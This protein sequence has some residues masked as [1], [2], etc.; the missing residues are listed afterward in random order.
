MSEV[1]MERAIEIV[2]SDFS[3]ITGEDDF[4]SS[5]GVAHINWIG[6]DIIEAT[7]KEETFVIRCEMKENIFFF[8]KAPIHG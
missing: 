8:K 2:R 6:F 3:K 5:I 1:N 4:I 7:E